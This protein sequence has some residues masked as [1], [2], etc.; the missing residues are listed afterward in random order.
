MP[1][2]SDNWPAP[3]YDI[4]QPKHI[5]ALGV[6]AVMYNQ[7]E[8]SLFCLLMDYTGMSSETTQWLFANTNNNL[9][10]ELLKRSAPEKE[11][12]AATLKHVL[13][14]A[15]CFDICAE[16]RNILMHSMVQR[17]DDDA[18][19]NFAKSSRNNPTKVNRLHLRLGDIRR[20][21]DEIA[22]SCTYGMRLH[23]F[24]IFRHA[25][26]SDASKI[27]QDVLTWLSTLPDTLPLPNRLS[28]QNHQAPQGG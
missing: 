6:A 4:G 27:P 15:D 19:L 17:A 1:D 10:L 8:F 25:K 23:T 18:V 13:H 11:Y 26:R 12:D 2:D 22:S 16:N 9:R 20:V 28:K 7:L 14:F 5:H 24:F 3:R 21:A